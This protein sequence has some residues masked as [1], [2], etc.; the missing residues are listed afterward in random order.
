MYAPMT[1]IA[2]KF[3]FFFGQ[4]DG[5]IM[6]F[7]LSCS[8]SFIS[9]HFMLR[10]WGFQ[11]FSIDQ[12]I[13]KKTRPFPLSM[14]WTLGWLFKYILMSTNK[15]ILLS[16]YFL[17]LPRSSWLSRWIFRKGINR[18]ICQGLSTWPMPTLLRLPAAADE[19]APPEMGGLSCGYHLAFYFSG[20][21]FW[22]MAALRHFYF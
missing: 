15:T 8:L 11:P 12:S 19:S 18:L 6:H 4:T 3:V 1:P 13:A 21:P 17:Y 10:S 9:L 14:A 7:S 16:F 5:F 20:M 2:F 22:V